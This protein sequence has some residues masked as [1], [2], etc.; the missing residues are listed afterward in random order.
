MLKPHQVDSRQ[1]LRSRSRSQPRARPQH[2][3]SRTHSP[4]YS[5]SSS[6]RQYD[7]ALPPLTSNRSDPQPLLRRH[8]TT[9]GNSQPDTHP[10][11]H[12]LAEEWQADGF[13]DEVQHVVD[14]RKHRRSRY[15]LP[16]L[17]T[18]GPKS[19]S[20]A[21]SG[22]NSQG[23][24]P[25]LRSGQRQT[26]PPP[27]RRQ[28]ICD[29]DGGGDDDSVDN[30]DGDDD[31]VDGAAQATRVP[32]PSLSSTTLSTIPSVPLAPPLFQQEQTSTTNNDELVSPIKLADISTALHSWVPPC[33]T[34]LM[35]KFDYYLRNHTHLLGAQLVKLC[36]QLI[37]LH[38]M[39]ILERL[40]IFVNIM[41]SM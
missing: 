14:Q 12:S 20:L 11:A 26:S 4:S 38:Y 39:S 7:R 6:R 19:S 36:A 29:D 33:S 5:I 31:T 28:I 10:W 17:D 37:T 16:S 23:Q 40:P 15:D 24:Q 1:R 21:E 32:V 35:D 2:G 8:L 25:H 9:R 13:I 3:S 30:D 27:K 22:D 34:S 41:E 18:Y